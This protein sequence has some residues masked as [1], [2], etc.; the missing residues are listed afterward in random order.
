MKEA[1]K[2]LT[3]KESDKEVEQELFFRHVPKAERGETRRKKGKLPLL[4]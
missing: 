3:V 4:S 2:E 1:N